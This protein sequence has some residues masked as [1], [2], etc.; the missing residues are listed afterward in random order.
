MTTIKEIAKLSGVSP[1]TVS[2]VINK[3]YSKVSK[4]TVDKVEEII[5]KLDYVPNMS[6][7]SLV[8]K[9]SRIVVLIIP[10][11]LINDPNKDLAMNNPFY[12]EMIN[13]IEFNLRK[14]GFYMMLRF[15]SDDEIY[16]PAL[17]RWNADGVI[18]LGTNQKQFDLNFI[19]TTM[20]LVLIDSYVDGV[21]NYCSVSSDDYDGGKIAACYLLERKCKNLAVVCTDISIPGVSKERYEGF[22]DLLSSKGISMKS[23][24]VYEGFPSY[25]YG[26]Q[27]AE[28]IAKRDD[29][30][31]I[32]A[33]SDMIAI[34]I[35]EGL[36][37][38]KIR[39]PEDISVI[40]FDGLFVSE[41][42]YPKLTTIKQNIFEKGAK[43]V[44]LL[45]NNMENKTI[46]ENIILP[47]TLLKKKSVR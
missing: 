8:S 20:P 27:V 34:G 22:K 16:Y 36:K 28:E 10:Q 9:N 44:E 4:T 35:I 43:S 23:N 1:M 5:K 11:N 24:N 26:L 39:V 29:I 41:I 31:G 17:R 46:K 25:E 40:G 12:G 38:N 7:R 42:C 18:V 19:N 2:N 37:I 14:K 33:F 47:V 13:S 15:V 30:D 6:A 45:V 3:K 32:F 21:K